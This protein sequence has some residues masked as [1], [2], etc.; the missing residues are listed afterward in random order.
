LPSR[1]N[2][3]VMAISLDVGRPEASGGTTFSRS[4]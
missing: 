3:S 1:R 4:A 2:M